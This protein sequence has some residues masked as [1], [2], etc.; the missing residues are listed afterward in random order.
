MSCHTPIYE[1]KPSVQDGSFFWKILEKI[2]F[3]CP[4]SLKKFGIGTESNM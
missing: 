2:K 1:Y 4:V 3:D